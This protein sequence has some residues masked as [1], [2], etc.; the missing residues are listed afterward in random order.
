[1]KKR[2][3]LIVAGVVALVLVTI[4]VIGYRGTSAH[5]A[6]QH[7]QVGP[8][9]VAPSTSTKLTDPKWAT[10]TRITVEVINATKVRGL[11][12]RAARTLRDQGF[13]VVSTGTNKEQLDSTQVLARTGHRD[14]A[15]R[16]AKAM[17][18]GAVLTR[19]DSSRDVDLTVLIGATW[20]APSQPFYP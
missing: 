16:A 13:D 10:G 6:A 17:G 2:E 7:D 3:T 20:R 5:V 19:P 12:R 8:S 1:M 4:A 15:E 11:A 14:W 9:R 18:G